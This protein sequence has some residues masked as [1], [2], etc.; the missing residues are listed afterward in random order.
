[1]NRGER[2][3]MR[4]SLAHWKRR[5]CVEVRVYKLRELL[6]ECDRLEG[7]VQLHATGTETA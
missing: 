2:Q 1:M 7:L 6:D 4:E 5:H 3:A